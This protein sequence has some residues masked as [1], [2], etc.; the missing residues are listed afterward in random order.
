MTSQ[1]KPW[2]TG[3]PDELFWLPPEL[4]PSVV[5]SPPQAPK[6]APKKVPI[7]SAPTGNAARMPEV[8]NM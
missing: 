2:P 4:S 1:G 7:R 8:E 3:D 6:K 5:A